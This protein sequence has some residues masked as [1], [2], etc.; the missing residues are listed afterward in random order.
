MIMLKIKKPKKF[1]RSSVLNERPKMAI[2]D[3]LSKA[4]INME[5]DLAGFRNL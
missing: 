3:I 5:S 2:F 4:S 1:P